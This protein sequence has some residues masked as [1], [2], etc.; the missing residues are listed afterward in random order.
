MTDPL[1]KVIDNLDKLYQQGVY[2]SDLHLDN[3]LWG[4]TTVYMVDGMGVTRHLLPGSLSLHERL[5]NLAKFLLEF[6]VS[7]QAVLWQVLR[8]T[9]G[10]LF[11]SNTSWQKLLHKKLVQERN[12]LKTDIYRKA[13][14]TCSD[15]NVGSIKDYDYAVKSNKKQAFENMFSQIEEPHDFVSL[16]QGRTCTLFHY[17]VDDSNWVIKRYNIKSWWHGVSR[18]FRMT[19]AA[20]SWQN[21]N[22]L[23]AL[24][25]PTASP[26]GILQKKWGTLR[27]QSYFVMEYLPG[28]SLYTYLTTKNATDCKHIIEKTASVLKALQSSRVSHGDLKADNLWVYDQE[29]Y[30]LD[31]DSLRY[32]RNQFF[33]RRAFNRDLKRFFKNWQEVPALAQQFKEALQGE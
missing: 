28:E 29:L 22:W 1:L 7:D 32:Y 27:R 18:A 20:H 3:I 26:I 31:L 5:N 21:A 33:F 2:Q 16:K 4:D 17:L 11:L 9:A 14:R 8:E 13:W 30:L 10:Q 6:S 19:R 23:Q 25:I 12:Q 24:H 15:V